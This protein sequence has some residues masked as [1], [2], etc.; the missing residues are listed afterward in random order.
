MFLK[1]SPLLPSDL[2]LTLSF[3]PLPRSPLLI[4]SPF[5]SPADEDDEDKVLEVRFV[6]D[7]AEH[8]DSMFKAMNECQLLHP[9]PDDSISEEED[10]GNEY[11]VAHAERLLGVASNRSATHGNGTPH[12]EEEEEMEV[13]GQFD[14]AD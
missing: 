1:S 11:D 7:A 9:D 4:T 12:D 3:N 6:P 2:L 8:L 5:L 13:Q 14:D 10:G